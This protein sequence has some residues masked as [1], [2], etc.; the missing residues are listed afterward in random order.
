MGEVC[1]IPESLTCCLGQR[2]VLLRPKADVDADY[3]LYVLQFLFIQNQ[4]RWNEG[5]GSTVS[6]ICIPILEKIEIP[7]H[8]QAET[9]I[10]RKHLARFTRRST[11]TAVSTKPSKPWRKAIFKS[12]FVDFDPVKATIA[13][14]EQGEDPRRAAMRAISGKTDF[15][16]DQI[17]REH[18]D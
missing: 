3:L 18:H 8:H 7:H 9:S 1:K 10:S 12:W 13:A 15:E 11:S 4:I 14:I 16:L 2:Q 5:T 6:K 17:L